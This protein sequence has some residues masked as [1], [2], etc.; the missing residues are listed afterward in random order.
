[1]KAETETEG[2]LSSNQ[3]TP[4]MVVGHLMLG[5]DLETDSLSGPQ[6]GTNPADL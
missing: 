2:I 5:E 6:E 3:G 1:M 4:R